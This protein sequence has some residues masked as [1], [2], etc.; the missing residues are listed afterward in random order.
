MRENYTAPPVDAAKA[1]FAEFAERLPDMFDRWMR[2][3][4]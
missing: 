2:E 1:G 4:S 3:W